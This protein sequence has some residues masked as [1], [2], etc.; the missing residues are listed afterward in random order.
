LS[1]KKRFNNKI[2]V[3]RISKNIDISK[4]PFDYWIKNIR[5]KKS[6]L[7]LNDLY[8]APILYE[9][10]AFLLKKIIDKNYSG[11]FHLSGVKD[12]TYAEFAKKFL[13]KL[14]GKGDVS[15][16]TG[17]NK[18]TD[19]FAITE[20]KNKKEIFDEAKLGQSLIL[21]VLFTNK[22]S[23][24]YPEDI[25][26]LRIAGYPALIFGAIAIVLI[27]LTVIISNICYITRAIYI[28][29]TRFN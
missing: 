12:I 23:K 11:V 26:K 7:A 8:F 25:R 15:L 10:S 28:Y 16:L 6:I 14:S 3:V 17:I 5:K 27:F 29:S 1:Y 22:Y 4:Y 18:K 20:Y 19:K 2:S 9:N 24:K 21:D 13:L